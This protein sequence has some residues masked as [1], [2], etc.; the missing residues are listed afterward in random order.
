[1]SVIKNAVIESVSLQINDHGILDL[2]LS[3]K[4][5]GGL[6]QGFGGYTLYLPKSF[7][8]HS[9]QSFA[10]HYIY[11]CMEVVGVEELN[12]MKGKAIRVQLDNDGLG[13]KIEGIG[14]IIKDDWFFP[15]LDFQRKGE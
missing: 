12:A 14:H 6:C 13:G 3:L 9:I 2:W 5:E 7:K 4:Y 8:H 1:M 10:G 15:K 11:R